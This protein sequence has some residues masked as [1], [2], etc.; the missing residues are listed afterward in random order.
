MK[1]TTTLLA[2]IFLFSCKEDQTQTLKAGTWL[3]H[4]EVT[5]SIEL[6]FIF[7]VNHHSLLFHT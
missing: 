3:A 7:E 1:Y 5:D 4:L 2:I 6:P